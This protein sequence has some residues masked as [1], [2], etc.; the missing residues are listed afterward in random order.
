V[1]G[2]RDTLAADLPDMA[3]RVRA[4]A[5]LPLA[6]GFGLSRPE[7][8]RAV[9]GIA[10]AAVVGSAL[11]SAIAE[12]GDSVELVPRVEQY[13]RWLRTGATPGGLRD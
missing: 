4:V 2:A 13:V 12:T 1:T 7:H 5:R 11:V 8:I 3:A 6:V 10:E 9:A